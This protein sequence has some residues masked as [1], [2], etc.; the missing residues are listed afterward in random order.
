M[1]IRHLE[2]NKIQAGVYELRVNVDGQLNGQD[3]PLGHRINVWL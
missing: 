3:P 2:K 1:I